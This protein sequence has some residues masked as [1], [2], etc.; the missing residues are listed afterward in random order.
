MMPRLDLTTLSS[1]LKGSESGEIIEK[2]KPDESLLYEMVHEG[3]MPPEESEKTLTKSQIELIRRWIAGDVRAS[4][5]R[6]S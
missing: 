3:L 1:V 2:N 6:Q 4:D 5:E